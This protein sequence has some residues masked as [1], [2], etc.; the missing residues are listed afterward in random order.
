VIWKL[1]VQ[2]CRT[3]YEWLCPVQTVRVGVSLSVRDTIADFDWLRD[4]GR[5]WQPG[6]TAFWLEPDT[7]DQLASWQA[8]YRPRDYGLVVA[9]DTVRI[10]WVEPIP[11]RSH[12]F[13]IAQQQ[14]YLNSQRYLQDRPYNGLL[15]SRYY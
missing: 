7:C 3:V 2:A 10:E 1:L 8:K 6:S 5:I 11:D 15:H 4:Y 14:A 13:L 12:E 9:S